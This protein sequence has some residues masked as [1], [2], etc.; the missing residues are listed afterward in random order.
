M[1]PRWSK[2]I[3]QKYSK[4]WKSCDTVPSRHCCMISPVHGIIWIPSEMISNSPG[5]SV[6]KRK[7]CQTKMQPCKTI[8]FEDVNLTCYYVYCILYSRT[9]FWI[10]WDAIIQLKNLIK[11]EQFWSNNIINFI[12]KHWKK[13]LNMQNKQTRL[14]WKNKRKST[15]QGF[16]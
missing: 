11:Y 5:A 3:V 1:W 8:H 4:E 16:R 10:F 2:E 12:S 6:V 14:S 9:E 13:F 15:C 7:P